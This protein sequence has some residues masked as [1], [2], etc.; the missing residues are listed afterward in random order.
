MPSSSHLLPSL[1][2]P[3]TAA[4]SLG[5]RCTYI[6]TCAGAPGGSGWRRI[7]GGMGE[8]VE[9][10]REKKKTFVV[11]I[12]RVESVRVNERGKRVKV[13]DKSHS[14]K[15]FIFFIRSSTPFVLRP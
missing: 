8:R 13:K 12:G 2:L 5:R 6:H 1:A 14:E 3:I 15:Y 4:V 7:R 9:G 10:W 11:E